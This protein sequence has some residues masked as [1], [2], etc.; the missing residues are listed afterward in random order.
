MEYLD[1]HVPDKPAVA[2]LM[3]IAP[4]FAAALAARRLLDENPKAADLL[5]PRRGRE[6]RRREL[7]RGRILRVPA[8]AVAAL[9]VLFV[10]PFTSWVGGEAVVAPKDRQYAFC[11]TGGLIDKVYV[12]QG[13]VVRKGQEVAVLDHREPDLRIKRE[14]RQA[15]MLAKEIELLRTRAV[16]DASILA[17]MKLVELKRESVQAE[18]DFLRLQREF[19]VVTAPVAGVVVTKD[20]ETLA[21]KRLEAGEAFCEVAELGELR[22]E[23]FVPEDRIMEAKPGQDGYLYLNNAPRDG[24]RLRVEETAPRS[25]ADPRLG[26]VYKVTAAFVDPPGPAKVGMKGTGSIAG[27]DASLW[28]ILTRR[29]AAR[30]N[31]L[32]L[33][34]R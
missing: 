24:L 10:V 8:V 2:T 17:K 14:E 13:S 7:Y 12:R 27:G 15:A 28:T 16:D 32:W 33:H 21:G 23:I 19:L 22:T 1:D 5:D 4:V 20:V 11:K 26:N 6:L 29:P 34:V 18:L 30:W 31:Q 9:I 25:E 3:K